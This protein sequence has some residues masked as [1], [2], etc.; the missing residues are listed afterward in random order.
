MV[1][2]VS[3]GAG[4]RRPACRHLG[5]AGRER[6]VAWRG[7]RAGLRG[8]GGLARGPA[9]AV[10]VAGRYYNVVERAV[11]QPAHGVR[12][13]GEILHPRDAGR[14]EFG[15]GELG[16]VG[17]PG[18]AR[19]RI[20][21]RVFAGAVSPRPACRDLRVARAQAEAGRREGA[22]IPDKA[23]AVS[24][25]VAAT[26]PRRRARAAG[27]GTHTLRIIRPGTTAPEGP[28]SGGGATAAGA[29][30]AVA[31]RTGIRGVAVLHPL[32][33]IAVHI[34]QAK[35]VGRKTPH[36]IRSTN[37]RAALTATAVGAVF[38]NFIAPIVARGRARPRRV[39]P[40]RLGGQAVGLARLRA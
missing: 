17:H 1:Q 11:S 9:L 39:F 20:I 5:V 26:R 8:G 37:R 10:R 31:G 34:E 25:G 35:G 6:Q 2:R 30:A 12:S 15:R 24:V 36:R 28:S 16:E 32:P 3:A 4:N 27:R 22:E 38:A 14:C 19:L 18:Q 40:F 29:R 21:E 7:H 33:H 13:A 23:D